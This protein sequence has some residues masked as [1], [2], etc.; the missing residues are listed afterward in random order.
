MHCIVF[1]ISTLVEGQMIGSQLE[2]K[3]VALNKLI[4]TDFV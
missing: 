1:P 2:P 4:K 3:Y